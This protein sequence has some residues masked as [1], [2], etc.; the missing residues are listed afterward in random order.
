MEGETSAATHRQGWQHVAIWD[1]PT[2]LFH[3]TLAV[4][5]I[6]LWISGT[7]PPLLRLHIWIGETVLAMLL[8]RVAWGVVGSRRSRFAD[9]VAGPRAVLAHFAEVVA[10]ARLGPAGAADDAPHAGHTRLGGWMILALLTLLGVECLTGLFASYRH[11]IG[12]PLNHLVGSGMDWFL[13]TIH[14]GTFNVVMAL[15]IVHVSAAA[16]YL[17][18]KRENLILP[19]IT[20]RIL[21]PARA[22]A[23]EGRL[24]NPLLAAVIF[25]AALIAV[26]A[27]ASL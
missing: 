18:R 10:V 5:F 4:L 7:E 27:V 26:L 23:Q 25:A 20:G 13:T 15:V 8:F 22:A 21:L 11:E 6:A 9:F 1:L 2:R 24:A 19:L 14:S 17:V 12:G 16:F 3:W